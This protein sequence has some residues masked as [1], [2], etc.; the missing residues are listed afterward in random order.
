MSYSLVI[1]EGEAITRAVADVNNSP[2]GSVL[3]VV[4]LLAG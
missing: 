4:R 1:F 2:S 3:A